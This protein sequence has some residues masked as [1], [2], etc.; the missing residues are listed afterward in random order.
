MD[1]HQYTALFEAP[2]GK[3]VLKAYPD[4][5]T[6]SDPWTIG[7]GCTGANIK[8]G[9]VWTEDQCWHEFYNRYSQA[10]AAATHI[11]G[12]SC[13]SKLNDPRRAVLTD[14]AFQMGATGLSRFAHMIAAIRHENWAEAK[15]EMLDSDYAKNDTPGRAKKNADV[16]LTGQWPGHADL[17]A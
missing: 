15:A 9:T 8:E 4:P 14:M 17:T 12:V 2:G 5:L 1:G 16:L 6:K 13:W 7:L 10:F 11:L 3:P